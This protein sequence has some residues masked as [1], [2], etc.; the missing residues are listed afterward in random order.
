VCVEE[1]GIYAGQQEITRLCIACAVYPGL[2]VCHWRCAVHCSHLISLPLPCILAGHHPDTQQCHR[3]DPELVN[4]AGEV[5]GVYYHMLG[6]K[7]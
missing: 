6:G 5:L 4:T 2:P 7:T 1:S 3:H